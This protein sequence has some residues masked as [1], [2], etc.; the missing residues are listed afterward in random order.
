MRVSMV[1]AALALTACASGLKTVAL[2]DGRQGLKLD[3]SGAAYTF[4][5]CESAAA[6]ACH[7]PYQV[8][9]K[10]S[11]GPY[12]PGEKLGAPMTFVGSARTMVVV[13]GGAPQQL[14]ASAEA[15]E[16][17]MVGHSEIINKSTFWSASSAPQDIGR[18][19]AGLQPGDVK[20]VIAQVCVSAQ[21]TVDSVVVTQSSG[22]HKVDE[23]A[24][25]LLAKGAYKVP[26]V[27]GSPVA[28]CKLM[29]S[30]FKASNH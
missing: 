24:K 26:L 17:S 7:G 11:S 6:K 12:E 8:L 28:T 20:T 2:P 13:C 4:D 9:S 29:K 15:G 16:R 27:D 14:P 21:G 5:W 10:Q 19:F 3:C 30:E 22:N 25:K 23:A 18:V 1:F